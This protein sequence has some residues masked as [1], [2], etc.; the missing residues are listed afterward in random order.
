MNILTK[1]HISITTPPNYA[2]S[3]QLGTIDDLLSQFIS[4]YYTI[5]RASS[6]LN[7]VSSV[8]ANNDLVGGEVNTQSR[9]MAL[10]DSSLTRIYE[11]EDAYDNDPTIQPDFC[12]P[13]KDLVEIVAIWRNCLLNAPIAGQITKHEQYQ[14]TFSKIITPSGGIHYHAD[15]NIEDNSDIARHLTHSDKDYAAFQLEAIQN[16]VTRAKNG[17]KVDNFI[18]D[19]L[20]SSLHAYPDNNLVEIADGDTFLLIDDFKQLLQEWLDF[21]S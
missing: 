18:T 15:S 21:I 3:H 1:Y 6:L 16:I 5:T 13:T 2:F 19:V 10:I 20:G 11:S 8:L 4:D 9:Q 17:L 12:L 7:Y 14:I